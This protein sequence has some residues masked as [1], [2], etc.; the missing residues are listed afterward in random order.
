[1]GNFY[2]VTMKMN[3]IREKTHDRKECQ[4]KLKNKK[5]KLH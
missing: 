5:V 4:G 1:M 2:D 3:K